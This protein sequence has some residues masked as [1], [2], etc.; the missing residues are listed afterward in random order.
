MLGRF[1]SIIVVVAVSVLASSVRAENDDFGPVPSTDFC[2]IFPQRC[3]DWPNVITING[4][5]AGIRDGWDVATAG[6]IDGDGLSDVLVTRY[7]SDLREVGLDTSVYVIWGATLA[8]N[9]SGEI[10][11][12]DLGSGGVLVLADI[13]VV[14]GSVNVVA[15]GD[16]D[17]DGYDDVLIGAPGYKVSE[18][19][20]L[21]S[22]FLIW[23]S[24]IVSAPDNVLDIRNFQSNLGVQIASEGHY[25]EGIGGSVS[26]AGDVD[27]DDVPDILVGTVT[28]NSSP[29][30]GSAYVV[31]GSAIRDSVDGFIDLRADLADRIELIGTNENPES[32]G[33]G[34]T[35]SNCGDLDNDG[36]AE[37]LVGAPGLNL[38][39]EQEV[40][41]AYL[42]WG[43]AVAQNGSSPIDLGDPPVGVV[44]TFL[45][46][47]YRNG[48]GTELSCAEDVNGLGV[49]DLIISDN[50][51]HAFIVWGEQLDPNGDQTI[52]LDRLRDGVTITNIFDNGGVRGDFFGFGDLDLDGRSDA[53]I[54]INY[55]NSPGV[56]EGN[57]GRGY[58]LW[59]DVLLNDADR[60]IDLAENQGDV[61]FAVGSDLYDDFGRS[62][63]YIDDLNGDGI[64]EVLVNAPGADARGYRDSG[65]IYIISG[66]HILS[67]R[68]NNSIVE[69]GKEQYQNL[70][71]RPR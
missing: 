56:A 9:L 2:K 63:S 54:G 14:S 66:A 26:S 70:V 4:D 71:E 31:K 8:D 68:Q 28:L 57:Y 6:D 43:R 64:K 44:S 55:S 60:L 25:L 22:A 36:Y 46:W 7:W 62:I 5:D 50:R 30:F 21:G 29:Y 48:V 45:G 3:F 27:G 12:S 47:D 40:G 39:G 67:N 13:S 23:G 65:E 61:L 53:L 58:I 1:C 37:F 18:P 17:N 41:A 51:E 20:T 10:N 49:E 35:L 24:S 33:F 15:V 16:I 69:I 19:D 38:Y 34:A 52:Q 59:A 11:L 32:G 42:F